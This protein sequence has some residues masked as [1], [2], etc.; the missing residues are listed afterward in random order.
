MPRPGTHR[1][2]IKRTRL[3]KEL[4]DDG[5]AADHEA[6]EEANRRLQSDPRMRPDEPSGRALG[7]KGERDAGDS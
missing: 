1:Y 7:P 3:R 2:D 4:E 6:D 5:V